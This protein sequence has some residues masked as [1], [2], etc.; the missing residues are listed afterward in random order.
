[1]TVLDTFYLLF[2]TDAPGAQQQ[3]AALDKQLDELAKKGKKRSEEENKRF[4]ELK[5]QR[6]EL[7]DQLKE[8]QRETDRLGD[9]FQS[10]IQGAVGAVTAYA[11]FGALKAQLVDA[12]NLNKALL[13]LGETYGLNA[14][15]VKAYGAATE[16]STGI[17]ADAFYNF[18]AQNARDARAKRVPF[19]LDKFVENIHTSVK[20]YPPGQAPASIQQIPGAEQLLPFF[21]LPDEQFEAAK[22]A[23]IGV[24]GTQADLE[25]A[26]ANSEAASKTAQ[27]FGK[28]ATE[29]DTHFT[30]AVEQFNAA[31]QSFA[32]IFSGHPALAATEGIAG[33]I[34]TTLLGVKAVS[35][36]ARFLGIGGAAAVAGGAGETALAGTIAAESATGVGIPLA[37]L[38]ALAAGGYYWYR[39][40]NSSAGNGTPELPPQALPGGSKSNKKRITD[41]WLAQGYSPGAA[42]GWA[43]NAQAESGFHPLASNGSHVGLYQWSA[44][45]RAKILAATGIDVANASLD[46]QLKAASW[47]AKTYGL[48]PSS[49]PD[50]NGAAAALISNKFEV[51][52][53]TPAGLAAE[54]AKRARIAEGYGA[55][56]VVGG[57]PGGE[58]GRTIYVRTGDITIETQSSDATGIAREVGQELKNQIRMAMSNFD[59]GVL[60]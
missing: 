10:M 30:G 34:L 23:G 60:Y 7:T 36:G 55:I 47:E 32:G 26:A 21:Q 50:N 40:Q 24:A 56:P 13:I 49:V 6:K 17:S 38:T 9:S 1:M 58:E 41:F 8:Q 12:N 44:A 16:R 35:A 46:D 45:R 27:E 20:N 37:I 52:A 18:A 14:V 57:T 53:L 42:A 5:K 31:V 25:A 28:I 54:A 3:A 29:I 11:S 2:K 43:A 59:D 33:S 4:Q 48:G 22:R 39:R 15:K 51:P 19:D